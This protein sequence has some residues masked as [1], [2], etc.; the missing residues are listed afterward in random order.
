MI[1]KIDSTIVL[2]Y[3]FLQIFLGCYGY[4]SKGSIPSL[5]SGIGFGAALV[6]CSL[7]MYQKK[8]GAAIISII[9]TA[10]LTFTFIY[11]YLATD[12]DL[13]AIL[14][15]LSGAVLLYLFGNCLRV[16]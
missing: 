15:T 5:A 8:K 14:A 12:K 2:I 16:K 7:G 13:P 11:R 3:G 6:V 1:R 9:L 10:V 4:L